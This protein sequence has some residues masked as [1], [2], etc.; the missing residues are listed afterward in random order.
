MLRAETLL[1][2][3][4]AALGLGLIAGLYA[5]GLVLDY[6][7]AWEST[8]LSPAA[9]HA[10]VT[11][12]LQPASVLSGIAL[13]DAAAFASLQAA[14]GDSRAGAPA[15]PWIHL[16]ALTLLWAVVL[17]RT[18]LALLCLGRAGLLARRFRLPLD[19]P[20][21]QRLA[22]LQRGGAAQ[23]AVWPYGHAPSPQAALGAAGAVRRGLRPE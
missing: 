17:P 11:W 22:R 4:A 12:V 18:L 23:V 8:L 7:A 6:R 13:P 20:Y 9:A 1:H 15:A 3:G 5:R 14:H 21:F 16:F 10:L 2:A 19:E